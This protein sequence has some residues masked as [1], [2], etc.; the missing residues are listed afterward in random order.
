MQRCLK[1]SLTIRSSSEWKVITAKRATAG[2]ACG[3]RGEPRLE[4]LEFAIHR[5]AERL[6][7]ARRRMRAAAARHD[8]FHDLGERR[9]WW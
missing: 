3:D 4:H 5:D 6:E 2:E 1:K 9:A 7:N 8:G